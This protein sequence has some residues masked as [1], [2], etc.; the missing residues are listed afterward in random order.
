MSGTGTRPL[1]RMSLLNLPCFLGS[2]CPLHFGLL[3]KD[4]RQQK[5]HVGNKVSSL[6]HSVSSCVRRVGSCQEIQP[7]NKI[8]LPQQNIHP[9][10]VLSGHRSV[11]RRKIGKANPAVR[12]PTGCH[13]SLP[14]Q[15][16]S[17]RLQGPRRDYSGARQGLRSK[18]SA[19]ASWSPICVMAGQFPA[20]HLHHF[21]IRH[22]PTW[23]PH[24]ARIQHAGVC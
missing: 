9:S 14:R 16:W 20:L 5:T 22:Q 11:K 6:Q 4:C 2:L 3:H 13:R 8:D 15:P 17:R 21:H 24:R 23:S 18:C 12:F 19:A 1:Y 10:A 7:N